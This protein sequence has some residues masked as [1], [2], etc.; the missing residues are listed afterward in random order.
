MCMK[1]EIDETGVPVYLRTYSATAHPRNCLATFSRTRN[2]APH[3]FSAEKLL[4]YQQPMWHSTAPP[5]ADVV[6][7]P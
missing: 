7:G 3:I 6:L 4:A 2:C 1:C 5:T